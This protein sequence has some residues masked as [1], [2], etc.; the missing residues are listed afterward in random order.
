MQVLGW[1]LVLDDLRS[2]SHNWLVVRKQ[3]YL[4]IILSVEQVNLFLQ[5]RY[6]GGVQVLEFIE[7]LDLLVG[8]GPQKLIDG[9]EWHPNVE[10]QLLQ[11]N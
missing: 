11:R 4:L 6:H 10:S 5:T 3:V 9:A 2:I 1:V 8:L 7:V